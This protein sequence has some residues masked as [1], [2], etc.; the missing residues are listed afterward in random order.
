MKKYNRYFI[1][2]A[3]LSS[4]ILHSCKY[5]LSN[6]KDNNIT[7]DTVRISDNYQI[8]NDSTMPSCNLKL[9]FIYPVSYED[10][11]SM[12]DS[13]QDIFISNF[14]DPSY[15]T[16]KSTP[17][18]ALEKYKDTYIKNYLHDIDVFYRNKNRESHDDGEKYLSFYETVV[19]S[20]LYNKNDI[21]SFQISQTNYKGGT[22]SY[23]LLKNYSID[24]KTGKV[25]FEKDIFN[26]DYEKALSEVFKEHLL[27]DNNVKT[28]ADLEDIGYFGIDEI[29][30]NENLLIDDKGITYIFNKG[31]YSTYKLDPI[32]IVIPYDEV[33]YLL[34]K[35]SPISQ[36]IEE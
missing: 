28:I 27:R 19:N 15:A 14:L 35:D 6:D 24:L 7:F 32:T 25:I 10:N 36:F 12:L 29:N 16:L 1:L 23:L 18:K 13:L 30:P 20:I 21:L 2:L 3:V 4:A 34:K 11:P 17:L 33:E 26:T 22:S 31:E 9:T 8:D 5:N